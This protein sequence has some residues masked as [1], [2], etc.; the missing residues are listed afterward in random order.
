MMSL[1]SIPTL[2]AS[3]CPRLG[4]RRLCVCALGEACTCAL[5]EARPFPR[6]FASTSSDVG[7][8]PLRGPLS[9]GPAPW[10]FHYVCPS[11]MPRLHNASGRTQHCTTTCLHRLWPSSTKRDELPCHDE[12]AW[13]THCFTIALATSARTLPPSAATYVSGCVAWWTVPNNS[14][15][16][17]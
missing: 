11:V 12:V 4:L 8:P 6:A 14:S 2:A 5:A 9:S 1:R 17:R 16:N 7:Q 15:G 10:P 13:S 3:A